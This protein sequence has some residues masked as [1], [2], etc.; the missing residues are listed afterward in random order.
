MGE[1]N[2][3][4]EGRVQDEIGAPEDSRGKDGDTGT[5]SQPWQAVFLCYVLYVGCWGPGCLSGAPGG[6]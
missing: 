5:Q 1:G 4:S 3:G 6:A 2:M